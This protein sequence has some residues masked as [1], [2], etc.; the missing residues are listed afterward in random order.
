MPVTLTCECGA[1]FAIDDALVGPEALC[2]E[3]RQPVPVDAAVTARPRVAL[4]ALLSL[5]LGLTGI[6]SPV[7][8]GGDGG[9]GW[10][11][12][13][14]RRNRPLLTG[15]RIAAAGIL[16]GAGCA[17]VT[18]LLVRTGA[19]AI[20]GTWLGT[21][22]LAARTDAAAPWPATTRDGGCRVPRPS[23]EWVRLRGDRGHDPAVD[24]LQTNREVL[25][26]H[27]RLRVYLDLARDATTHPPTL[28]EYQ[29]VLLAGLPA[30]RPL[31]ADEDDD[32]AG[33]PLD[34]WDIRGQRSLSSVDGHVGYEW[35]IDLVRGGQPWRVVARIWRK[36]SD[37][38]APLYVARA[39]APARTFPLVEAEL[40]AALDGVRLTP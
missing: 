24:D 25:L 7:G 2:P 14:I 6:L 8:A 37:K 32:L 34:P 19:S 9:R 39:Y 35:T 40:T 16:L 11:L 21:R 30:R 31:L 38:T 20:P 15:G 33:G 29:T 13:Q 10:R 1:R 28:A 12:V 5:V 23:A 27:R 18:L 3:C 4:L 17:A 26:A 36:K 22:L